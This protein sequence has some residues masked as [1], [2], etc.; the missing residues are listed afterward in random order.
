[1]LRSFLSEQEKAEREAECLRYLAW[2]K[3]IKLGQDDIF[4]S[5]AQQDS[6]S[7]YSLSSHVGGAGGGSG[8]DGGDGGNGGGGGSGSNGGYESGRIGGGGGSGRSS[9]I[10]SAMEDELEQVEGSEAGLGV[11]EGEGEGSTSC[12][13]ISLQT[14]FPDDNQNRITQEGY[15]DRDM[16]DKISKN[17]DNHLA[18]ID[19]SSSNA[20][21]DHRAGNNDG[22][23]NH[24][25]T[26]NGV[27]NRTSDNDGDD[28]RVKDNDGDDNRANDSD[29]DDDP[30]DNHQWNTNWNQ[31]H[32]DKFRL[33]PS[34]HRRGGGGGG[35]GEI[36][37]GGGLGRGR[38][39]ETSI[40]RRSDLM[41]SRSGTN[42][43]AFQET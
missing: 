16:N 10:R 2:R 8:G 9:E 29:G 31:S 11:G 7:R 36:G 14:D 41:A 38:G 13:E 6:P 42:L 33:T 26:G 18:K 28:N 37:G 35:G 20:K 30:A 19:V 17:S 4:F 24:A 27:D 39:A 43:K 12:E 5:L 21:H 25:D 40:G 34:L 1:M 22:D 23:D 32:P 15:E 3:S